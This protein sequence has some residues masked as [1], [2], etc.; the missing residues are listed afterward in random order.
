MPLSE[1]ITR[2]RQHVK[3]D[4]YPMSI[5]E[6]ANLYR[7]EE[8]IIR[9]EYQR[10]FRW[11]S[12][13]K[14]RLIESL[15]LGIPIPSIFVAQTE[16]GVWE[17]IDGLQRLST[18]FQFMGILRSPEGEVHDPLVLESTKYLDSLNGVV[19]GE[20]FV[21]PGNSSL[22]Q[23]QQILLK[24]SKIDVKILLPESD[25]GARYELFRRLNTLG[26]SLTPQ[27]IRNSTLVSVN[28]E[29]HEW[30]KSLSQDPH[31]VICM[32]QTDRAIRQGSDI[33][34]VLRFLSLRNKPAE[35]VR[36]IE[37]L[38]E[39][40]DDESEQMAHRMAD[41]SF[42]KQTE[43]DAFQTTFAYLDR[44]LGAD[45]FRRY[46]AAKGKYQGS[47]TTSAF[48][49]LALGVGYHY[50][51]YGA[52]ADV[53]RAQFV[54]QEIWGREDFKWSGVRASTRIP[55]TVELGRELLKP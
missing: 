29:F 55:K 50:T 16:N 14:S 39:F 2:Q 30:L 23:S 22:D 28:T 33:D 24:R 11:G 35:E 51:H 37:E 17:V 6:L 44:A 18:I 42:D 9:P 38:S 10:L 1:E 13:Q 32:D 36:R 47:S 3:A 26:S 25:L 21:P 4:G 12:R 15:L 7:D 41:G 53:Q 8:M 27:E 40:L 48:E 20:E 19:W 46:D 54:S 5:G 45:S 49:V 52:A 43:E 34:F 31:F